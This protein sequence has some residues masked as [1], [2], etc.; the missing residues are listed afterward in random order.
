MRPASGGSSNRN[1]EVFVGPQ[2]APA[3]DLRAAYAVARGAALLQPD[4]GAVGHRL[5][6]VHR[7]SFACSFLP[8]RAEA[9]AVVGRHTECDVRLRDD[10]FV[11]LRHVLVRSIALPSGTAA[12]RVLDLHTASGFA[13]FGAGTQT[14]V[15]A[16]G[17]IAIGVGAYA[18]VA[19]PNDG[20]SLPETLPSV[21]MKTPTLVSEQLE[22]LAEAMSPYRVNARQCM[23][24]SRITLMPSAVMAFESGPSVPSGS[25]FA[26]TLAR[27]GRQA[28]VVIG[29]EHL[30]RGILIGR[31]EKCHCEELR[32]VTAKGTSRVH[33]LLQREGEHVFAY[34]LASTQGTFL[35][36]HRVRRV[37]LTIGTVLDL[38]RGEANVRMRFDRA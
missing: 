31:S 11:A 2:P 36:S 15:F 21:E 7:S 26:V 25:S 8:A 1:T 9:F 4:S 30:A 27:G 19:F 6:S 5:V 18:L 37:A 29:E 20:G 22:A 14:A 32:R 38:G 33:V 17:P 10:P 34:D 23:R 35:G 12:L 13:A 16:E 3:V 28:T 24:S